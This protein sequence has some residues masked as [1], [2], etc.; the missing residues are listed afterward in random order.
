MAAGAHLKPVAEKF[1]INAF[2]LRRHWQ[3]VSLNRKTYLRFGSKLSQEALQARV[4]EEQLATIDHLSLI[5]NSLY[6]ALTFAL[7]AS[8]YNAVAN[9]ARAL[10]DCVERSARLSGEWKE[11][12][13]TTVTNIA[14]MQL[15]GVAGII[16]GITQA[17]TGFPEA[18]AKVIE[19]L[20]VAD[21]ATLALPPPEAIDATA[22]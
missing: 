8:D 1:A 7:A 13:R 10:G 22:E 12:P 5:R 16:S 6:K 17:L 15:P 21:G 4:A 9:L 20:R 11:G 2:A 3:G 18:R 19:F 14:V